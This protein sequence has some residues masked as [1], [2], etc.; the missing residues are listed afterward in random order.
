MDPL[1]KLQAQ[2]KTEKSFSTK[3]ISQ[4]QLIKYLSKIKKKKS[5]GTDGLSQDKLVLG[6]K[7]LVYPLLQIINQYIREGAFPSQWKE[8][9]VTPVFKK[10]GTSAKENYRPVSSLPTASKLLEM[11]VNDQTSKYLE[12]N[13]LL[14]HNQHE[15]RPMRRTMTAWVDIQNQWAHYSAKKQSKSLWPHCQFK[16][17]S[18][19]NTI[20]NSTIRYMHVTIHSPL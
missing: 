5:A 6:T 8:A 10:G 1:D 12:S 15:F 9:L 4:K 16:F 20:L 2:P 17:K 11:V 14:P 19:F 18:K 3:T 7:S 13:G